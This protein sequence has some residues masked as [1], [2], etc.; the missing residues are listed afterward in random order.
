MYT[1]Y[2]YW[3]HHKYVIKFEDLCSNYHNMNIFHTFDIDF[4]A[5]FSRSSEGKD[6]DYTEDYRWSEGRGKAICR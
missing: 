3:L 2:M 1:I 6:R 5:R 4:V